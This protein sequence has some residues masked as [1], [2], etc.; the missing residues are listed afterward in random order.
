M[1]NIVV[2]MAGCGSRFAGTEN[3][4]PKPLIEVVPGKAMIEYVIDY[5]TLAE[6]HRC[7]F[8]CLAAHERLLNFKHFF[9][10]KTRGHE[11]ILA[12][13]M[14]AGP[15]ASALLAESFIDNDNE[16]MVAYCDM[17]LT[18]DMA[19]FLK[20][21]RRNGS[22]GGVVT[23]PSTN[24]MDSYAQIDSAGCVIRTAE[25]AIISDTATAGLYYFRRGRDFVSSARSMLAN[26][27]DGIGEV[28][29]SPCYNE[30]IRHGKTVR[31]YPIARH[32]KIEM[33]TPDDLRMAR[34]WLNGSPAPIPSEC[35]A[36]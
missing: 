25:K 4:I 13:E 28:F 32:E 15:A 17:F 27:H 12:N 24:P 26:R 9:H 3:D 22:D 1:I 14:T 31:A 18:I 35:P 21:N 23:Y 8:V 6:Q 36:L 34:S 11:I 33:G 16:L 10:G 2:P 29:V 19:H 20:W 7:I 30:L 5:L